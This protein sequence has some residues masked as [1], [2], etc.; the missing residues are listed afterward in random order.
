MLTLNNKEVI[1]VDVPDEAKNF[2]VIQ[3]HSY[4]HSP[5][6]EHSMGGFDFPK[7]G[8]WQLLGRADELDW[9]PKEWKEANGITN[10]VLLIKK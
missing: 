5:R 1:V 8:N 6:V 10:Q 2:T 7:Y 9:I 4:F 3:S